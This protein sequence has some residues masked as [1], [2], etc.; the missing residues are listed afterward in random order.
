[1]FIYLNNLENKRKTDKGLVFVITITPSL[2]NDEI[3]NY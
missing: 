2:S 1:M 3:R